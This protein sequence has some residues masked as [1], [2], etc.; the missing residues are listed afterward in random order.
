ML[1]RTGWARTMQNQDIHIR[2][3]KEDDLPALLDFEQGVVAAERPHALNLADSNIRY[4]DLPALIDSADAELLVAEVNSVPVACGYA[5]IEMSKPYKKS[6]RHCYLGFMYVAPDW[7]GH[8]LNKMILDKL[9]SWSEAQGITVFML[10]VYA[11]NEPAI[12]A[13]EKAGFKP[14]LL[15]MVLD[16]ADD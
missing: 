3:A 10:D 11:G 7:R 16:R 12:R 14:N 13:Y 15:E 9:I 5:R 2:S 1:S 4:Y 6:E 8:G